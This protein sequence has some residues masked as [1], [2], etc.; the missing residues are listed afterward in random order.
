MHLRRLFSI[1][2]SLGLV[3]PLMGTFQF[4]AASAAPPVPAQSGDGVDPDLTLRDLATPGDGGWL[5]Y[6]IA[7][8]TQLNNGDIIAVYD[9][10]PTMNDLPSNIT[11]L[12]RRST[13]GG[14][15]WGPQTI[16]RQEAAPNGFGDPS[17]L[18]DRETGKVFVFYAASINA[19]FASSTTGQNANDPNVLHA[20]Y[21]VSDDNGATWTHRRITSDIKQGR[22]WG[23]MFA[24]SGEGIQ[25]RHGAHA[26]RLIQQYTVRIGG[27]NYAVSVFSDDGGA[28]WQTSA[29]VGPGADEN[30]TVELSNGDVMLNSRAAPYRRV[31]TSTDGGATYTA[32]SQDTELPDPANNGS[33]IR[34]FPDAPASDPK[35]KVLLFSNT[36]NQNV[37]RN[38]TVR[39][40]CDDGQTWPVSKVVQ[41]GAT[42]YSTLTALAD[43]NGERGGRYGLFYER[44]GY[45]HLSFTSFDLDWL[46]GVCGSLAVAPASAYPGGV[47]T[48]TSVTITNQSGTALAAGAI[49]VAADQRFTSPEVAVPA[50]AAGAS[51]V[52]TVP[53]T[54][55]ATA[56]V[57]TH[58]VFFTYT[59]PAGTS[60]TTARLSATKGASPVVADPELTLRPVLDAMYPGGDIGVIGDRIQPWVEVINTGNVTLT[61]IAFTA[62]NGATSCNY[63]S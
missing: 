57:R 34:A 9:G 56:D 10:R 54:A 48:A 30:K 51:T 17:V 59:N 46:G 2:L 61:Q 45:R 43:G 29:P 21:S 41:S 19:G 3:V 47:S 38:L 40:S 32:F 8:Q 33:I 7:A 31:A 28:S 42:G 49:R 27:Q 24:A 62:P 20:D 18:V 11:L 58:D 39:M 36:A 14:T 60:S 53:V 50:I 35:S 1:L 4:Q 63:S 13:D 23:G 12:M 15:T 44:D 37:R 26:G 5:R 55:T 52:V 16:I 25:L 22:A 6:R